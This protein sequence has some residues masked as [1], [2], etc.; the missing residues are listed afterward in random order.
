MIEINLV[1]LE[2]RPKVRG[3]MILSPRRWAAISIGGLVLVTAL[4]GMGRIQTERVHARLNAEWKEIQDSRAEWEALRSRIALLETQ[5]EQMKRLRASGLRWAPRLQ[6]LSEAVVPNLWF[7]QLSI[8][9][10]D[11]KKE[12][13]EEKEEKK[14]E[15]KK[16]KGKVPAQKKSK[17]IHVLVQGVALVPSS[18]IEPSPISV[19][20]QSLKKHPRF[21]QYF[22]SVE[23][24]SVERQK[25]GTTDVSEFLLQLDVVEPSHS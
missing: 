10:P 20:L 13:K 18:G 23:V 4:L 5:G 3:Q 17:R 22:D 9:P 12:A 1:P 8:E 7:T 19:Y 14:L 11:A 6:V 15:K 21:S 16:S 25:F 24:K 2:K